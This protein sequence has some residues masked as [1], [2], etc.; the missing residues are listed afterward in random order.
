M[1]DDKTTSRKEEVY[2]TGTSVNQEQNL[3]QK[4]EFNFCLF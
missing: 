3:S 1:Q 4:N 2:I